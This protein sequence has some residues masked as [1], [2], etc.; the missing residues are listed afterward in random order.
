MFFFLLC[1][2]SCG[3]QPR[4]LTLLCSTLRMFILWMWSLFFFICNEFHVHFGILLSPHTIYFS[5]KK[6]LIHFSTNS[7]GFT[8]EF[9]GRVKLVTSIASLLGVGLYNGFL[10]NVPLRKVFFA[11]TLLGSTLGMTQVNCIFQLCFY[12][13]NLRWLF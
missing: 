7:L 2:F 8:P 10:K 6:L 12:L 4:S 5:F 9:L 13:F 11:T 1:L 3:K